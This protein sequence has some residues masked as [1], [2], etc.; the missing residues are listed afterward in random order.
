M[1]HI[2]VGKITN[3]VAFVGKVLKKKILPFQKTC[4]S[5]NNA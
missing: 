3:E 4:E 2:N 1:E 5:P